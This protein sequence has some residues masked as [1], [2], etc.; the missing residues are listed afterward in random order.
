MRKI[1][2]VALAA[3]AVFSCDRRAKPVPSAPV[4]VTVAP[5]MPAEE[6][7]S[8]TYVGRIEA[9]SSV[10]LS[11]TVPGRITYLKIR[12]GERVREGDIVAKVENESLK[13]AYDA[14][15]ATYRRAKDACDRVMKVKETV[16]EV[17]IVEVETA[18]AQ[19]KSTLT[20]AKN[21]LDA[22]TLK[23]PYSGVIGEVFP[24]E[25]LEI[26]PGVPV[27]TLLETQGL[28][29]RFPVPEGEV[30]S[31]LPG[32]KISVEIPSAGKTVETAV[33]SRGM[34]ASPVSH[35][36]DYTASVKADGVFPGMLAKVSRRFL[37]DNLVVIPVSA[38]ATGVEGR[39]VWCVEDSIVI[40]RHVKVGDFRGD[41]VI[42]LEGLLPGDLV[43]TE[44][45]RKVSSGMH[46]ETDR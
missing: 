10:S 17:K 3:L 16:A 31:F 27:A 42:V 22:C 11:F 40:K 18:L 30:S 26:L 6:I 45:A 5:A 1:L 4:K 35:T 34:V 37:E 39:Y 20:S 25:G 12:Q 46:V 44:G 36:Y 38:L 13:A 9:L 41:G 2:V 14:A 23:A 33:Q 28:E 15:E 8:C 32:E 19:A 29:V 7:T 21:A 43:I 24:R